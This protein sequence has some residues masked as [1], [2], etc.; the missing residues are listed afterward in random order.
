MNSSNPENAD[1]LDDM[2]EDV[3]ATIR[4]LYAQKRVILLFTLAGT[5]LMIGLAHLLTPTYRAELVIAPPPEA[6]S[7]LGGSF[8]AS[9]NPFL[10]KQE[11]SRFSLFQARIT[12]STMAERLSQESNVMATLFP[13]KW[14]IAKS[15]WRRPEGFMA[16]TVEVF[17]RIIGTP[18]W[19]P[20]SALDIADFLQEEIS[21]D[22]LA[23]TGLLRIGFQHKDPVF[24]QS[25]LNR[26]YRIADDALRKETLAQKTLYVEYLFKRLAD[27]PNREYRAALIQALTIEEKE[28]LLIN[29]GLPYSAQLFDESRVTSLPTFPNAIAFMLAGVLFGL[30]TGLLYALFG[31]YS[32]GLPSE[33]APAE[34]HSQKSG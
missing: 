20:P 4:S 25:F 24:A 22:Y 11:V 21:F 34:N 2:T 1:P 29:S 18:G 19:S 8:A 15:D 31:I 14:D 28:V 10:N 5:V 27:E 23:D 13:E 32:Q 26:L 16:Q 7:K 6:T 30:T 3:I 33:R 9:L 12:S 17:K